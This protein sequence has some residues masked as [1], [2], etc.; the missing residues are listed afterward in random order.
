MT[1]DRIL[2]TAEWRGRP[3]DV[4]DTGGLELQPEG[5]LAGKV[6]DAARAAADGGRRR[7][8]RRST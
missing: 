1:R 4:V 5:A 3:F 7:R 2:Y 6:A 8:V